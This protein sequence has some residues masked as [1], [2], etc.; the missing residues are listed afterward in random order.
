MGQAYRQT[1]QRQQMQ[2]VDEGQGVNMEGWAKPGLRTMVCRWGHRCR[3]VADQRYHK[4]ISITSGFASFGIS[5][6]SCAR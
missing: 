5:L 4:L 1:T 3:F 2:C 6:S